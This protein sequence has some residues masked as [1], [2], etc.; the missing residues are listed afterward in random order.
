MRFGI[1][2]ISWMLPKIL[3]IRRAAVFR[4]FLVLAGASIALVAI[5]FPALCRS[6]GY[7]GAPRVFPGERRGPVGFR[8]VPEY[9]VGAL[10]PL[11]SPM[12]SAR[13]PVRTLSRRGREKLRAH[14][15]VRRSRLFVGFGR[16]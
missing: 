3:R 2:E 7:P 5:L 15:T 4:P 6:A 1:S 10:I 8:H 11:P 13:A 14:V 12:R 9:C 16:Y